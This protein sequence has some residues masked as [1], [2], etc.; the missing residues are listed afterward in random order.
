MINA[1]SKANTAALNGTGEEGQKE[2]TLGKMGAGDK[3]MLRGSELANT[4]LTTKNW[5]AWVSLAATCA[6]A[7]SVA[8]LPEGHNVAKVVN[9]VSGPLTGILAG[10]TGGAGLL[11]RCTSML[12]GSHI[13]RAQ[14]QD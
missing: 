4:A 14:K 6:Q 7:T 11:S 12:L 8:L 2:N 13:A 1:A 10:V 9:K 5:T 3:A